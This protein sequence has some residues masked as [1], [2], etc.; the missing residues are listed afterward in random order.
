MQQSHISGRFICLPHDIL[1]RL[2]HEYVG[3]CGGPEGA[4]KENYKVPIL[5][6][7][8]FLRMGC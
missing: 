4:E 3:G 8:R 1:R 5:S 6:A 7:F 2:L